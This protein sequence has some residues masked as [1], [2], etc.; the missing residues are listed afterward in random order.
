MDQV[1]VQRQI[2]I[3]DFLKPPKLAASGDV[4]KIDEDEED[5]SADECKEAKGDEKPA[6]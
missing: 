4:K 2:K 3:L 1:S 5:E 6:G